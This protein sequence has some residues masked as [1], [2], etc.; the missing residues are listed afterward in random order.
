V[1]ELFLFVAF[2]KIVSYL[3]CFLLLDRLR[4]DRLSRYMDDIRQNETVSYLLYLLYILCS[5]EGP[6][7]IASKPF[8]KLTD[9]SPSPFLLPSDLDLILPFDM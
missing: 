9:P 7:F 6:S 3:L 2:V 4:G 1:I 5:D 8:F